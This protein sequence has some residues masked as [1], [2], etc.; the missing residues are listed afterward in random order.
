MFKWI[1]SNDIQ[2]C[3]QAKTTTLQR[4]TFYNHIQ[5][6]DVSSNSEWLFPKQFFLFLFYLFIINFGL[7]WPSELKKTEMHTFEQK[8]QWQQKTKLS[9]K[10]KTKYI[11][12][13]TQ[14]RK[15][16]FVVEILI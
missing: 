1:I 3:L 7:T 9:S 5:S 6:P 15:K 14:K 13:W 12:L 11:R 10:I 16:L 4:F 8:Q 2:K